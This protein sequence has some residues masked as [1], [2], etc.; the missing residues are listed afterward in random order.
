MQLQIDRY[1]IQRLIGKG[2]MGKI[3][4][5]RDPKL[6]RDV[7]IKVLNSVSAKAETRERFRMEARAIAALRHPNIVELYDFS[8]THAEDLFLVM[9]YVPGRTLHDHINERGAMSEVT[10]LCIGH[11][12]VLALEH[13]HEQNVVHRDLKPE[14]VLLFNG[15]VVLTDFGIVKEIAAES[16]REIWLSWTL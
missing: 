8:G 1:E 9:E 3:Y 7:A 6:G 2:A 16:D 12:L 11:E 15:R 5:A 10:T 14:N 4:L 13:A